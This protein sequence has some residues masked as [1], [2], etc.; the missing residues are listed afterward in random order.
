ER[1]R[2]APGAADPRFAGWLAADRRGAREATPDDAALAAR[3]HARAEGAR[4]GVRRIAHRPELRAAPEVMT[5]ARALDRAQEQGCAPW[6]DLA[7]AAGAGRELW[8][9]GCESW[10]ALPADLPRGRFVALTVAGDSMTPLLH[11]GDV[12]LVKLG[13]DFARDRVVVARRPDD[14][15]VVKRIGALDNA[16][17]ELLSLNPAFPPVRIERR[18]DLIVGTVVVRWC[19]H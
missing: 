17:V 19:G 9:E 1:R 2:D 6:L 16:S 4:L 14:G 13:A 10:V 5:V 7:I 11:S 18:D 3:L 15:Y 12:V 8:D